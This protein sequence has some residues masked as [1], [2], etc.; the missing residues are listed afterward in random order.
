MFCFCLCFNIQHSFEIFNPYQVS[1]ETLLQINGFT[2]SWTKL[3]NFCGAVNI[4]WWFWNFYQCSDFKNLFFPSDKQKSNDGDGSD[5][6][7]IDHR[8]RR[9]R[10]HF[11]VTQLQKLESFFARNRY[12]DM[13]MREDI[14]QWCSLTESRV[15]VS[16]EHFFWFSS[17]FDWMKNRFCN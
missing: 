11:T 7:N 15:R 14:A 13:A 16:R 10:T 5:C 6:G 2:F 3:W 12:P 1:N 4:K 9:Q 8:I 17:L